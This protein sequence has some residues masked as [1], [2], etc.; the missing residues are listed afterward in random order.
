[1]AMATPKTQ[2]DWAKV[3]KEK[4]LSSADKDAEGLWREHRKTHWNFKYLTLKQHAENKSHKKSGKNALP[5]MCE[6]MESPFPRALD[7]TYPSFPTK[8]AQAEQNRAR[9]AEQAAR[10]AAAREAKAAQEQAQNR[11]R[12]QRDE[13]NDR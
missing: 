9:A 11:R 10:N 13:D 5:D 6:P 1:M 7:L 4:R 3:V 8:K 2:E 12:D